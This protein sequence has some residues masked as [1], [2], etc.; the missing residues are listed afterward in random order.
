MMPTPFT[1]LL[2]TAITF[3]GLV[4]APISASAGMMPGM[5]FHSPRLII[6]KAPGPTLFRQLG[7]KDIKRCRA[8][9]KRL[10]HKK[11]AFKATRVKKC[12]HTVRQ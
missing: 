3:F 12:R 7:P 4:A 10:Q 11:T 1:L 6:P 8:S 2:A 9:A 5:R